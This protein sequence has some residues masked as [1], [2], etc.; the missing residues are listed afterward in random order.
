MVSIEKY[1]KYNPYTEAI[2]NKDNYVIV[3][4]RYGVNDFGVWWTN[5]NHMYDDTFGCSTRGSLEAILHEL[6]DDLKGE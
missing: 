2:L 5:E 4:D 3:I 6:K 1:R